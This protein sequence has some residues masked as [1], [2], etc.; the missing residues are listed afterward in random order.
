MDLLERER[1][2]A[3]L[4]EAQDG[5]G[6]QGRVVFVTGEP[7][8]GKTSLVNG[9]SRDLEPGARLCSGRAT[10][11]R[12]RGR[13]ARSAISSAAPSEE[14][15]RALA[16]GGAAHEVQSLLLARARAA[17]QPTVLVLED[18]H[19]ADDATL[20]PITVLGRRIALAARRSS[21]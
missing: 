20:D 10:T 6:R 15:E 3:A 16:A 4:A 5:G 8:I 19:W 18:V 11:S 13:S 9:S 12:S 1:A 7:G 14:L 17:P 2:L 21:F